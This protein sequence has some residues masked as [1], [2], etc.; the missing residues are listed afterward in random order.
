MKK[1]DMM[2]TILESL[3]SPWL[4]LILQSSKTTQW[5]WWNC[6]RRTK[7]WWCLHH[8]LVI[9]Q[10]RRQK[11]SQ[12]DGRQVYLM[13]SIRLKGTLLNI[14]PL[15]ELCVNWPWCLW[16]LL[17]VFGSR[18][19]SFIHAQGWKHGMGSQRL[20]DHPTWM[21]SCW[22]WQSKISRSWSQQINKN[23]T[24]TKEPNTKC[25]FIQ[26]DLEK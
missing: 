18:W 4:D 22:V 5:S 2:N 25:A 12:Q 13:H 16:S 7:W 6:Q 24:L 10:K 17:Q 8:Y 20:F 23:R 3:R 9:Q 19:Q 11:Q 21:Q 15:I 14:D 1:T 26:E